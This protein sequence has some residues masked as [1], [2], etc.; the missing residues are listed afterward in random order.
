MKRSIN[1][2][3][4][5]LLTIATLLLLPCVVAIAAS[6]VAPEG[7]SNAVG[8]SGSKVEVLTSL[9]QRLQK[10]ISVDFRDTPIDDVIR[11]CLLY[12]SPSPRD[13]S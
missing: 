7:D 10:K 2:R 3:T 12:T 1:S 9:E 13:C 5:C 8:N 11:I 6:V 4:M